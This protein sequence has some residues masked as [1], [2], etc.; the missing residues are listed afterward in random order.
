MTYKVNE[1]KDGKI[2]VDF[3]INADEWEAEVQK[4]YEK[5]KGKYKLDGFRQGKI[6]R[7]VLEKTYGEFLFYEDALNSVCDNSF[8][9]MLE[10]ETDI[11]AVDYP[12]ISV[13][14][15][16][17]DG[18]EWVATITLVPDVTLGKYEGIE[19]AKSKVSVTEKEVDAKLAE[20]Q[21]KVA[22]YVDVTDRP[23]KMGDLVNIDFVGSMNGVAF[24]GGTAKDYELELGSHTFIAGFEDQVAGMSID[25]NKD[26]NVTFPEQYGAKELAG[27]P[28]V[29][30]V[31][32]LAIREKQVPAIDDKFAEDVSEFNT[33]AELKKDTKEKIK[34]EKEKTAERELEEKLVDAVVANAELSVPECMVNNQI[35]RAVE[36]MK[37][38]LAAQGMSYE[39]YLAY[40]GMTDKELRDSRK[41]DVEKQIRTTLVLN[42]LVKKEGIKAEDA[43]IEAKIEELAA[44]M[45][46]K[47]AELKKTMNPSQR[48]V[49]EN[50]I[51]SEK[52][53]KLLKEKN[54]IK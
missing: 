44:N 17:K 4:A 29:F 25:E 38:S 37:R 31:K 28:A 42:E 36:D 54:T 1:K 32:L 10:K 13:K 12:D 41:A 8:F 30:A 34:A 9:E 2:T 50:N 26:V 53:I 3:S 40:V 19:V 33:L 27:K 18:V 11:H 15:V 14:N 39:M 51:V 43:E 23:A 24:E 16:S 46:K 52:V 7:K 5:N 48:E 47:P 49:I 35:N 45:K 20:L 21:E 22:R 6:P